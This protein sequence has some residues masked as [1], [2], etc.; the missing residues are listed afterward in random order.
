MTDSVLQM[1]KSIERNP[2]FAQ[3]SHCTLALL[4]DSK[5]DLVSLFATLDSNVDER[6]SRSVESHCC[7]SSVPTYPTPA[8]QCQ[9]TI[10]WWI[11]LGLNWQ[12]IRR[13]LAGS[14]NRT[15]VHPSLKCMTSVQP[16]AIIMQHKQ[17]G[18]IPL[19]RFGFTLSDKN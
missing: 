7:Q 16:L 10:H 5:C 14:S 17:E 19:I 6:L 3:F 8:F 4:T 18:K 13:P 1:I 9:F 15:R 2:Y 12:H 11:L